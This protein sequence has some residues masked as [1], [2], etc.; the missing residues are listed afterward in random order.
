MGEVM[1][2][3]DSPASI[4]LGLGLLLQWLKSNSQIV[5]HKVG[6]LNHLFLAILVFK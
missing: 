4:H 1:S 5:D 2:K 3:F 6:E